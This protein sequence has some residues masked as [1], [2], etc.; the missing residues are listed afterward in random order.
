M[1]LGEKPKLLPVWQL[2]DNKTT[3]TGKPIVRKRFYCSMQNPASLI[4]WNDYKFIT[5]SLSFSKRTF[6]WPRFILSTS[7]FIRRIEIPFRLRALQL[8][9]IPNSVLLLCSLGTIRFWRGILRIMQEF[10][11][12]ASFHIN[13]GHPTSNCTTC[14]LFT[15]RN[16]VFFNKLESWVMCIWNWMKIFKDQYEYEEF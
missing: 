15:S 9:H 14:E 2:H 11:R 4:E 8:P 12:S 6:I 3:C 10:N 5:L 13:C 1:C 16:R 7:Q